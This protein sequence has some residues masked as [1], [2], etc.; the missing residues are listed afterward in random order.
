[1]G[2]HTRETF[3]ERY[4]WLPTQISASPARIQA[5][6]MHFTWLGWPMYLRSPI[7]GQA[8]Q[9]PENR[10]NVRCHTCAKIVDTASMS[11]RQHISARDVTHVGKVPFLGAIAI[12]NNFL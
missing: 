4:H 11:Q 12:D 1:M 2:R 7:A 5:T 3:R 6:D 9:A 10:I 8:H